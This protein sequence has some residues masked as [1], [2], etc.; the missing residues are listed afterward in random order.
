MSKVTT[1]GN[2]IATLSTLPKDREIWCDD[3]GMFFTPSSVTVDAGVMYRNEWP[4][5]DCSM[6]ENNEA[7]P[8]GRTV[9]RKRVVFIKNGGES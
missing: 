1:V 5:E 9:E 3:G 2:L 8:P 6:W 7:T 4:D